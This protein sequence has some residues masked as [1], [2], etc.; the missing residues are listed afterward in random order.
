[1]WLLTEMIWGGVHGLIGGIQIGK[2]F[3]N[4]A[5]SKEVTDFM[6]SHGFDEKATKAQVKAWCDNLPEKDKYEWNQLVMQTFDMKKMA[7]FGSTFAVSAIVFGVVGFL[8][9][10]LTKTWYYAGV[11]PLISFMLNNPFVRFSVIKNMPLGEK[12]II[13]LVAQFGVCYLL[14]YAGALIGRKRITKKDATI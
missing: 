9:G 12:I 2:S 11:F 5:M 10:I 13:T 8:S 3:Q 14:A 7:G 6:K 1:M 4:P